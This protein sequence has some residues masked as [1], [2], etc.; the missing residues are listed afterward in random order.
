M[1]ME[2]VTENEIKF[3]LKNQVEIVEGKIQG[4][5][6]FAIINEDGTV[7]FIAKQG[8]TW[9]II[10]EV[11]KLDN[12]WYPLEGHVV[13][14]HIRDSY[15]STDIRAEFTSQVNILNSHVICVVRSDITS[16]IPA[17]KRSLDYNEDLS[18]LK[19]K[20]VYVYDIKLFDPNFED[21]SRLLE[22]K[23]Y[24]DPEVTKNDL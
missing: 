18:L 8:T 21:I 3:L 9:S 6:L 13:K 7:D 11:L 23:I 22:G 1:R 10:I 17:Y 12:T 15:K 19:G 5:N 16:I 24:V 2:I 14:G 20:G 4:I